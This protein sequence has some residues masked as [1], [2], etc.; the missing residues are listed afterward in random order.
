MT[1]VQKFNYLKS[2]VEG[3]ASNTIAGFALTHANYTRAIE[4][5]HERFGQKHKI[6]QSYMQ[7]LLDLPAPKNNLTSLRHFYDQVETYV[8]GLESFGQAQDTYESLLVPIII[9]KLPSEMRRNLA[10]EHGSNNWI[11]GELRNSLFREL[12]ILEAGTNKEDIELNA[13]ATFYT[14]SKSNNKI[15]PVP[16]NYSP[17]KPHLCCAFCKD[18]HSA[19]DCTKYENYHQ[20]MKIVKRDRLCF[21][22]LGRHRV[23]DCQSRSNCKICKKRHHTSLCNNRDT[24]NAER[25]SSSTLKTKAEKSETSVMYSSSHRDQPNVLLQTAVAPVKFGQR[26]TDAN[27]LFDE[28]AQRSFIL[29]NLAEKLELKPSGVEEI[30]ILGFG[31][32]GKEKRV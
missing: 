29:K 19:N 24:E 1:E 15:Q 14:Q 4:L 20:R 32:S 7:A 28:G 30:N 22:C 26:T 6:V 8:R 3:E 31:D 23:S 17:R 10:R 12:K 13:T 21:N 11:L 18:M 16:R 5:L 9:K 2:L 27:I 25:T